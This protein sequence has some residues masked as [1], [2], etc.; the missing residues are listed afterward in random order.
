MYLISSDCAGARGVYTSKPAVWEWSIVVWESSSRHRWWDGPAG[1]QGSF[2]HFQQ[3]LYFFNAG[4]KLFKKYLTEAKGQIQRV[5]SELGQNKQP[6]VLPPHCCFHPI[7]SHRTKTS[8][9]DVSRRHLREGSVPDALKVEEGGSHFSLWARHVRGAPWQPNRRSLCVSFIFFL[10]PNFLWFRQ[11]K[12]MKH[13]SNSSQRLKPYYMRQIA[14][15]KGSQN[16]CNVITSVTWVKA[17]RHVRAD[18]ANPRY[19]SGIVAY[20]TYSDIPWG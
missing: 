16:D 10:W 4:L 17:S 20:C 9:P 19:F 7:P 12:K 3:L 2:F 18:Y 15:G 13:K 8:E 14:N 5:R 11:D 1:A 6:R